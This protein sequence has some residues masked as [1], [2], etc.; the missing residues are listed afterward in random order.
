MNCGWFPEAKAAEIWTLEKCAWRAQNVC[1]SEPTLGWRFHSGTALSPHGLSRSTPQSL[2]VHECGDWDWAQELKKIC[3]IWAKWG[4]WS[5]ATGY[6]FCLL[7]GQELFS[8][9]IHKPHLI[10]FDNLRSKVKVYTSI[11]CPGTA[12]WKLAT[13]S[14]SQRK[15]KTK[16]KR[17]LR[18]IA[19][20][21]GNLQI[22]KVSLCLFCKTFGRLLGFKICE[23]GSA[24]TGFDSPLCW[25]C[26]TIPGN[27]AFHR[28]TD[29]CVLQLYLLSLSACSHFLL[30][31]S[32][33]YLEMITQFW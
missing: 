11:A 30:P 33:D 16:L 6:F 31:N 22:F 14:P 26:H 12:Q 18:N 21:A 29:S 32:Q 20:N 9:H 17:C 1:E 25:F 3:G 13:H 2:R 4:F 24:E 27:S 15:I 23:C 10:R 8:M 7:V 28:C 19:H 5:V